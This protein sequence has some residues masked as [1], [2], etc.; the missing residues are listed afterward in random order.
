[1]ERRGHHGVTLLIGSIFVA[2]FGVVYG[3]LALGVML[4]IDMLPDIDQR[5][6]LRH[7]GVTHTLAFSLGVSITIA[8]AIAFPLDVAQS[9]AVQR[10]L[11]SGPLISPTAVWVFIFGTVSGGLIGHI[12]ADVLSVGGGMKVRPFWPMNK[13][14]A[15]GLWKANSE[16]GNQILLGIGAMAMCLVLV[17]EAAPLFESLL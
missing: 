4:K 12:M 2:V 8:G 5:C 10:G 16:R 17:F 13:P 15:L 7:R 6:Q 11:I 14:I 3:L 9:A 1:M